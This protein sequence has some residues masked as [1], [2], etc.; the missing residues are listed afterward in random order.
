MN[1]RGC[2]AA[3]LPFVFPF[4]AACVQR[5]AESLPALVHD[6][7]GVQIIENRTPL[8]PTGGEWLVETE[9][10]LTI[11]VEDGNEE[12]EFQA[13]VD[14]ER[15][16]DGSIIVADALAAQLRVF[17]AAGRFV[18]AIGRQGE[19]PGEFRNLGAVWQYRDSIAAWDRA[20]RRLT[21]FDT[22]GN[23]GRVTT[24]AASAADGLLP[25]AMGILSDGTI[26]ARATSV[27]T[28]AVGEGVH[29]ANGEV[30]LYSPD[31][32][33]RNSVTPLAGEEWVGVAG[34][35][36][37]MLFVRPFPRN[38]YVTVRNDRIFVGDGDRFDIAVF[39]S[40]ALHQ[41][42]RV[43]S[44]NAPLTA[45]D[46]DAYIQATVA[47]A[48][49]EERRRLLRM[50]LE[51]APFP[52][53][54]PAFV[55]LM[56]DDERQLWVAESPKAASNERTWLVFDSS[57]RWLGRVATPAGERVL[58]VGAGRLLVRHVDELGVQSIRDYRILR[59]N[60]APAP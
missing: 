27:I 28:P 30:M 44:Q 4:V 2:S 53:T 10:A 26:V 40:G 55:G 33:I 51:R 29:R 7:A 34:D 58:R 36:G 22:V 43:M 13:I 1:R 46:A 16:D 56:V 23:V 41:H 38:G 14:A 59:S 3:A 9:P 54:Y 57:G 17:D 20:L 21:V 15:L 19:G 31:G 8:W 52:E 18:R 25:E 42:I 45:A 39:A 6:S 37:V 35:D 49:H 24:L 11:G 32:E 60:D 48:Q 47:A 50:M 12:Y 5:D